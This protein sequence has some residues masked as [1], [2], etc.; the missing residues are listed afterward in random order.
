MSISRIQFLLER[1]RPEAAEQAAREALA[2]EPDNWLSLLY[3]GI[4][5]FE[6]S[7]P[8]AAEEVFRRV[9]ALEPDDSTARF[10]IARCLETRSRLREALGVI[11]EAITLDP[12]DADQ[13]GLKAGILNRMN[14]TKASLE[15]AE[16]GLAIDPDN[17]N[18]R[19]YRSI[20]LGKSGRHN[21]AEAEA[22][23]L[24]SDDPDSAENHSARGWTLHLQGDGEGAERH[25]IEALRIS[26]GLEDARVGLTESMKMSHP[27][28]GWLMRILLWLGRTPWYYAIAG[29]FIFVKAS[30]LAAASNHPGI[31]LAGDFLRM[32]LMGFFMISLAFTPLFNLVLASSEKGRLALSDGEKTSL[33]WA[34]LP[35]TLG[36]IYFFHWAIN[37]A[38]S[39]P[40]L[41]IGWIVSA[42]MIGEIWETDHPRVR[43]LMAHVAIGVCLGAAY[44]MVMAHT[45]VRH[46]II[47]EIRLIA[48][49]MKA[50]KES[51]AP[52]EASLEAMREE[53]QAIVELRKRFL[54][55]PAVALFLIGAFR[56]NIREF[57]EAR[58][59]DRQ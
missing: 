47:E 45:Y 40:L 26:P 42:A 37:G 20:A 52:S 6:Q 50:I 14:R 2:K 58:V 16:K 44:L 55:Y 56:D 27:L 48:E 15:A 32:A 23:A 46:E 41:T 9:S 25:F 57:F 38:H 31:A 35:M 34:A 33:R 3:L 5:L 19:F 36:A 49:A 1:K 11:D 39:L 21:E 30:N 59:S 22:N 13:Y 53:F 4:A 43:R 7:K 8:K 51:E 29:I 24:L 10:W 12:D 28:T 17:D 54:D 18:C